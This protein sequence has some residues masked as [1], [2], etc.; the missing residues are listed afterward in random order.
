MLNFQ[1]VDS[2]KQMGIPVEY[3]RDGEI[4]TQ[5]HDIFCAHTARYDLLERLFRII[6]S[7]LCDMELSPSED[8]ELEEVSRVSRL[9]NVAELMALAPYGQALALV[10]GGEKSVAAKNFLEITISTAIT[11]Y[12]QDRFSNQDVEKCRAMM[13]EVT[14]RASSKSSGGFFSAGTLGIVTI[15]PRISSEITK[16]RN[17]HGGSVSERPNSKRFLTHPYLQ[18]S[19]LTHSDALAHTCGQHQYL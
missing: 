17:D 2:L 19:H 15:P 12:K 18:T 14:K 6:D 5:G 8:S 1:N 13:N 7:Q 11:A 16:R 4:T 10:T 3:A 9:G